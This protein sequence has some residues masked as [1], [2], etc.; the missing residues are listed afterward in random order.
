MSEFCS[1]VGVR[2]QLV[3]DDGRV[4]LRSQLM[5]NSSPASFD[6]WPEHQNSLASLKVHPPGP[7]HSKGSVQV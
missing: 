6:V 5:Q 2:P 7:T 4:D 1:R 3:V